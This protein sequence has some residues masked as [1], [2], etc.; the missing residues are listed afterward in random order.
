[1]FCLSTPV[2]SLQSKLIKWP[3]PLEVWAS[4]A[5]RIVSLKSLRRHSIQI[6]KKKKG[7]IPQSANLED[8]LDGGL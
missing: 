6:K 7:F 4:T 5:L 1:M 3:G 2:S 8:E